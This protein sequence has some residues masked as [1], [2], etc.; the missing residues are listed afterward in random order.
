MESL[1]LELESQCRDLEKM[2]RDRELE[3]KRKQTMVDY[4]W[5]ISS[6]QKHY[7][8]PQLERL[9]LEELCY[10]VKPSECGKIISSFR[11]SL[12]NEPKVS[13]LPRIMKACVHQALDQRPKEETLTDWVSKKTASLTSMKLRPQS[14]VMPFAADMDDIESQSSASTES[15]LKAQTLPRY[16]SNNNSIFNVPVWECLHHDVSQNVIFCWLLFFLHMFETFGNQISA[17]S[18]AFR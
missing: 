3:E 13:D 9:E 11:D 4:S 10:N 1:V 2:Y 8:V 6:P 18:L 12:L 16:S 15:D 7:E 14:K 17:V 5:L